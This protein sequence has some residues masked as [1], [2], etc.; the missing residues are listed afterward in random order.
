MF[1][2]Q[3][4]LLLAVIFCI[5][6]WKFIRV[7]TL[8]KYVR[9]DLSACFTKVKT[10]S[11]ILSLLWRHI[12]HLIAYKI[13]CLTVYFVFKRNLALCHFIPGHFSRCL[14]IWGSI[15]KTGNIFWNI[16]GSTDCSQYK[17]L[18]LGIFVYLSISKVTAIKVSFRFYKQYSQGATSLISEQSIFA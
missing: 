1:L 5:I 2:E 12:H 17:K 13:I 11:K 3:L 18:I 10:H 4:L 15:S 16:F 6:T 14:L 9:I 8:T 7:S